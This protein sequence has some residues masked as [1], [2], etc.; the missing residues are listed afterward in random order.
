MKKR[1]LVILAG[2][3]I[4]AALIAIAWI[5]WPDG[6]NDRHDLQGL[7]RNRVKVY[8]DDTDVL[9]DTPTELPTDVIVWKMSIR[10]GT[11]GIILE[12]DE[13]AQ[14]MLRPGEGVTEYLKQVARGSAPAK[15][16]KVNHT[17]DIQNPERETPLSIRHNGY[18]YMVFILDKKNWHF[19]AGREPFEVRSD[20]K[21][22]YLDPQCAWIVGANV[23]VKRTPP[24]GSQCTVASFIAN[25]KLDQKEKGDDNQSF[26]S[27][28]NFYVTLRVKG[29]NGR[30][31]NLPLVIDPDV[32]YP[33]GYHP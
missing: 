31:S 20:K 7:L 4:V 26:H 27:P 21:S 14:H 29:K 11:D 18:T 16:E 17:E 33:G 10:E 8:S 25:A 13:V 1:I 5:V 32:G 19:T 23:E 28:F 30:V 9:A 24:I 3:L 22:Y 15:W 12:Y 2:T 6:G